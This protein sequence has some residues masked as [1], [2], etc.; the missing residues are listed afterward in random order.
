VR[1]GQHRL[2]TPQD[3]I[4]RHCSGVSI[5]LTAQRSSLSEMVSSRSTSVCAT[6]VRP[7]LGWSTAQPP[8]RRS[9][10]RRSRVTALP[11]EKS[12]MQ[13]EVEECMLVIATLWSVLVSPFEPAGVV[14]ARCC[15]L[16]LVQD[17]P[18]QDVQRDRLGAY[19]R[20]FVFA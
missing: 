4:L 5:P 20:G 19:H 2:W 7:S 10:T 14:D 11:S 17:H 13:L 16:R 1:S 15:G 8:H 9:C 12:A 6:W 3:L 18:A